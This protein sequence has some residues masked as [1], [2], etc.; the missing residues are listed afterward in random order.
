MSG[1]ATFFTVLGL[2][3]AVQLFFAWR[4]AQRFQKQLATLRKEG[5]VAIG[6]GGKRYRGGRAYVALVADQSGVVTNGLLLTGM[7]VMAKGQPFT[8]YKGFHIKE[9]ISGDRVANRKAK[10][11]AAARMAAEHID[12]YLN[13]KLDQKD[14]QKDAE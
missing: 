9:I 2:A 1:L 8:D 6:L 7:T 10:V 4:Q 11:V 12:A 14:D 13:R 3:W 5:T